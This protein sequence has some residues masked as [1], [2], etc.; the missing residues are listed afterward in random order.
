MI[1]V[2]K[3]S[4]DISIDAAT[5]TRDFLAAQ[6]L[7][8][9]KFYVV[10]RKPLNALFLGFLTPNSNTSVVSVK[11]WN[12]TAYVAVSGLVDTS[13][14]M[15]RSGFLTWNREQE[16]QAATSVN[17]VDGFVYEIT[18]DADTSADLEIKGI[19]LLFSDDAMILEAEPQ[20]LNG[21]FYLENL[22]DHIPF[23][24]S[25]RN[26]IIQ[27]L[28]NE[29]KTVWGEKRYDLDIFDLNDFSQL[30]EASKNLAISKAF[31]NISDQTDGKYYQ[32]YMD[33]KDLYEEAYKTFFLSLDSNDDGEEQEAERNEPDSVSEG[34]VRRR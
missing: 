25:A 3:N 28:R 29:G 15:S 17:S 21:D 6:F 26:Q 13:K 2:F 7:A 18:V 24:Q 12:G 11:Y 8:T 9:D 10:H 34:F 4:N 23:H 20:L 5:Y 19:N 33:Y 16:N 1:K 22:T 32:K 31:F 30:A 14:G 27:R